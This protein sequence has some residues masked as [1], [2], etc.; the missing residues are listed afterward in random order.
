[1]SHPSENFVRLILAKIAADAEVVDAEPLGTLRDHRAEIL[2]TTGAAAAEVMRI[3][4][5][6][7]HAAAFGKRLQHAIRFVAID[8]MPE[9]RIGMRDGDGPFGKLNGLQS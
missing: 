1:V 6:T 5:K 8:R 7:D 2:K 9:C 3:K 4:R